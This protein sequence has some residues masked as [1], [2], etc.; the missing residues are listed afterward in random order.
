M[1]ARSHWSGKLCRYLLSAV[2]SGGSGANDGQ[3]YPD[4]VQCHPADLG[5]SKLSQTW[6][7]VWVNPGVGLGWV[8]S[9]QRTHF[10]TI[11]RFTYWNRATERVA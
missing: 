5:L 1:A 11:I 9:L 7:W 2:N 4:H 10:A 8:K 6:P 3:R